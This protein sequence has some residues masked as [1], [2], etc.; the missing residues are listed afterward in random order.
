MIRAKVIADSIWNGARLTTIECEFPRFILAE[1]N[2][3]RV[4]SRNSAS[5]RAIPIEKMIQ[6][7]IDDP[8]MPEF[9]KKQA[10]MQDA[11]PLDPCDL[12]EAQALW[13]DAAE[14]ACSYAELLADIGVH[15]QFVNRLLEPFSWHT[16]IIS[17]TEWENFF[18]QRCNPA[19]EP[20]M[21]KLAYAI[22][23][24]YESSTPVEQRDHTPY[25]SPEEE[26]LPGSIF[27]SAARCARVSY[28]THDGK[29]DTSKDL[30]LALKLMTADPMHASPFE[31]VA[32][33]SPRG[34]RNFTGWKQLREFIEEDKEGFVECVN[35]VIKTADT[36]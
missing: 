33:A 36:H 22:R 3:H 7:V 16:V 35:D 11:G 10:G 27:I 13:R 20:H 21:Q 17:S 31:H 24:A 29:R 34:R 5:S 14:Q 18:A 8:V 25:L 1:L 26:L 6:R 28:L 23:N 30:E 4:F 15:K 12:E 9:G 19:A 32:Y 2:T